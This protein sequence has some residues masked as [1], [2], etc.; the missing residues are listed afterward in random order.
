MRVFSQLTLCN[1]SLP[2]CFQALFWVFHHY[3]VCLFFC[4]FNEKKRVNLIQSNKYVMS[5]YSTLLSLLSLSV[6]CSLLFQLFKPFYSCFYFF[7]CFWPNT[8]AGGKD[9]KQPLNYVVLFSKFS[10]FIFGGQTFQLHSDII[11]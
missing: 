7:I 8:L 5:V 2:S 6:S 4:F 1:T 11:V 9:W 10:K 3:S